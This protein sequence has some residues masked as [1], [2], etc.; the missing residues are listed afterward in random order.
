MFKNQGSSVFY[1]KVRGAN[2]APHMAVS[3][4]VMDD[5]NIVAND[6][7]LKWQSFLPTSYQDTTKCYE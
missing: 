1:L 2:I 7:C 5:A 4:A 3:V 6:C